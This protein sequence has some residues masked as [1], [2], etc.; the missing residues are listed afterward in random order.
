VVRPLLA[1]LAGWV[2]AQEGA[3]TAVTMLCIGFGI[4]KNITLDD[5]DRKV[6]KGK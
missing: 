6:T 2:L 4:I 1:R 5:V 3:E